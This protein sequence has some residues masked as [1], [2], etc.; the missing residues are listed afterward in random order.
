[1]GLRNTETMLFGQTIWHRS[2]HNALILN[3]RCDQ[4]CV[5]FL[6]YMSFNPPNNSID[7]L[8][9]LYAEELSICRK[10]PP[11]TWHLLCLPTW[12]MLASAGGPPPPKD[13]T[14]F[15]WLLS[16]LKDIV[17]EGGPSICVNPLAL[18]K[19]YVNTPFIKLE[20]PC[21]FSPI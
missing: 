15:C 20:I 14:A 5:L 7:G 4:H 6:K 3:I 13:S 16:S 2:N 21:S 9:L 10:S 12:L 19:I 8:F 1:M 18:Y 11:A 17:P